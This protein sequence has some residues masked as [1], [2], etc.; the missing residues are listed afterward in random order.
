MR[1]RLTEEKKQ[2]IITKGLYFVERSG[3]GVERRIL[4]DENPFSNPAVLKPWARFFTLH[5][6]SSLSCI[7]EYLAIDSGGYVYEQPSRINCSI[8]LDASQRSRDGV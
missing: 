6:A 8:W 5:C 2:S 7:N 1:Y 4:D 3:S